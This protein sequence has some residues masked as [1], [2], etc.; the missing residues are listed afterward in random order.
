V[1]HQVFKKYYYVSL[2]MDYQNNTGIAFKLN[3]FVEV[4]LYH[5]CDQL[6]NTFIYLNQY[7]GHDILNME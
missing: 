2:L 6:C 4:T 7:V 5:Q 1:G 3:D